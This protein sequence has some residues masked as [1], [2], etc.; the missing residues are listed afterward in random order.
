MY[1]T[2]RRYYSTSVSVYQY[3]IEHWYSI[4]D[5]LTDIW[6]LQFNA[7]SERHW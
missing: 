6:N 3:E 1:Q 4:K 7:E 2:Y 5:I